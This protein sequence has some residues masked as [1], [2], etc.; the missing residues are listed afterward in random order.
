MPLGGPFTLAAYM[1]RAPAGDPPSTW[2]DILQWHRHAGSSAA[3]WA[4]H[5][6]LVG[7]TREG[8]AT[9]APMKALSEMLGIVVEPYV[10]TPLDRPCPE[11]AR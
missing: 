1:Y 5:V 3:T 11:A 6:W 9:C 7:H 10:S 8:L 4:T 2:G